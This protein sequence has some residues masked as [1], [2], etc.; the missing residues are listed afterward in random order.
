LNRL[1]VVSNRVGPIRDTARAG[2]LAVA[3]V[4]ALRQHG[5]L[6]FGWSG[7]IA[8]ETGEPKIETEGPLTLATCDLGQEDY[9]QYY[10]GFANR[11]LWPLFHYRID[12]T[13]FSRPDFQ[14]YLRVNRKFARELLPL[15]RPDD[16]IWVHDYH[17]LMFG[18]EL[19]R[20]GCR[21]RIGFFLH[22]PFPA[23]EVLTT[24]PTNAQLVRALFAYDLIGFQTEGDR[25]CFIHYVEDEL[26]GTV[27]DGDKVHAFGRTIQASVFSIGIDTENF[28]G[29]ATGPDAQRIRERMKPILMN[30][31][32][33]IIGVDRLDYTKGLPERFQAF[34]RLLELFPQ[35]RGRVT[36]MQIAP[37]SRSDVEEYVQIRRELETSAGHINGNFSEYDW[38]PIRYLNKSFS[39]RMLAGLYRASKVGFV[40]PLRDGM[41]LVA[42]EYVAA[43][44]PEDPGV[45]VLSRF[46]G[47]A[48]QLTSALIVNPYDVEGMAEALQAALDMPLDERKGRW[49]EMMDR[50]YAE[51]IESWRTAFLSALQSAPAMA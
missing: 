50:L 28:V 40:T 44:D 48:C 11:S 5:G 32:V 38:T 2:G 30:D 27:L 24:L 22:T 39:R 33:Q 25:R 47:A 7:T 6:W 10:L 15:L 42:K 31:R 8:E 9:D 41:N 26:K 19:R 51:D 37:P 49:A 45:L 13:A 14:G 29:F 18:E 17:F 12:L 23:P 4:D 35:N 43:Q 16:T 1:V 21:Q 20:L 36:F 46:A 3:L 34:Q